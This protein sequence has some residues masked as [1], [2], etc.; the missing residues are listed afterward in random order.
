MRAFDFV[1]IL[2]L[3]GLALAVA[4]A[5]QPGAPQ[6]KPATAGT[7]P[8]TAAPESILPADT[9][10]LTIGDQKMTRAQFEELLSALAQ[11]GR[12][13]AT[14]AA[15]R[16]VAEQ[17]GELETLAQEA[18][19]RKMDQ[20]PAT[21]Q[22][23]AIQ[24]DNFLASALARQVSDDVK[25]SDTDVQAYYNLHKS[26]YEEAQASHI[27]IRYK[28]SQVPLKPNQKDLTDEEALAKAQDIRKKLQAGG[29][30]AALAKA[31]SDDAGSGANGGSLGKFTHGQM[32]AAFDQ[33]AFT[34]PVGQL[35][36]PVKTQF[37]YHIIKVESRTA[38]TFEEAKPD[39]E[40][41][42]KPKLTQEALDKIKH[43]T[44]VTLNDSYFGK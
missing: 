14:P 29:D 44:P 31:E 28:G 40:K 5:Q 41:Q 16:Q 23:M 33:A 2:V 32:V 42:I 36:E 17:F 35:S 15:R 9:V 39:I 12:P 37:G 11:N 38:K 7:A 25:L 18:R 10:V 22:M 1:G 34:L 24:A 43:Q 3:S 13:A 20:S 26:E 19:K 6:P 8:A 27:L 30:F 21:K 4:N